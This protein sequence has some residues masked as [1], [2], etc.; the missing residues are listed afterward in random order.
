MPAL[1]P[2][3]HSGAQSWPQ[4]HPGSSPRH[5]ELGAIGRE[6]REGKGKEG[7]E[8]KGM[9]PKFAVTI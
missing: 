6:G 2:Q 8:R 9:V 3:D 1:A 7:R 5:P 4:D